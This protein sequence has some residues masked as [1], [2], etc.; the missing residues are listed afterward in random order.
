MIDR[1]KLLQG[2]AA[3]LGAM[4]LPGGAD[5]DGKIASGDV[6]IFYRSFGKPG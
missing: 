6:Q 5:A 1:R 3:G 2:S 4:A